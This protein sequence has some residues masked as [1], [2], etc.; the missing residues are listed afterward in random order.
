MIEDSTSAETTESKTK[1]R[2][3]GVGDFVRRRFVIGVAFGILVTA[4]FVFFNDGQQVAHTLHGFEWSL[5][6]LILLLSLSNYLLRFVKWHL[7]LRW[8][9]A[10]P[11]AKMT[12]FVI[13]LSG[14]SMAI[15]PG[16]VGE[17]LKPYLVRRANGTPLAVTAPIVI[18][19]RITDAVAIL[20]LASLGLLQVHN[21]WIILVAMAILFVLFA[22]LLQRQKMVRTMLR[23]FERIA[24][25]G[26]RIETLETLYESTWRMFRPGRLLFAVVIST[27]SWAGECVAFFFVLTGLGF[28]ADWH[29]L[30]VATSSLAI[31]TLI[32]AVTLLPGGL[33][34]AELSVT[35]LLILFMGSSV[36]DHE[37]AATATLL[38]RFATFWFG[39][40]I[41]LAALMISEWYLNR[42][43]TRHQSRPS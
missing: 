21:G 38:I 8:V 30:F 2:V 7:Y 39:I 31:A 43:S 24:L 27:A 28:V 26:K 40:L 18:S 25:I 34:A 17:F 37:T 32:G 35:G 13:F 9:G 20:V 16:K 15:T 1:S 42:V 23:R 6:P 12:S 29:L 14:L 36:I 22:V 4:A 33:G 3:E 11:I 10:A 41:G 5:V 19:E